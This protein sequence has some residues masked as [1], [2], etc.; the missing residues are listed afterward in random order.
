MARTNVELGQTHGAT[1]PHLRQTGLRCSAETATVGP[2]P[3]ETPDARV[4]RLRGLMQHRSEFLRA[5]VSDRQLGRRAAAGRLIRLPHGWYVEG[6]AWQALYAE[7]RH[8]LGVL[9][10]A[11]GQRGTTAGSGFLVFSYYSAAVLHRLPLYGFK[12]SRTHKTRALGAP[13]ARHSAFTV[14]H[15]ERLDPSSITDVAGVPCTDLARTAVDIAR[16]APPEMALACADAALLRLARL[17]G[18]PRDA[19]CADLRAAVLAGADALRF[20]QGISA[21]RHILSRADAR[22]ESPLE[23]IS[24]W[25]LERLGFEVDVQI[26]VAGPA[27]GC[28]WVDFELRGLDV[29]GEVDGAQKYRAD[30]EGSSQVAALHQ[31]EKRRADW[32]VGTTGKRLVRWGAADLASIERF[33]RRLEA[34]GLRI[35]RRQPW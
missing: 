5:H 25:Y 2:M 24:R 3:A 18:R 14:H 22:S 17:D 8:L 10:T 30:G 11:T 19:E 4:D 28:Y 27:G 29:L 12:A 20:S 31:R 26:P 23:S 16:I 9:A 21:A 34:F 33:A 7:D 15:Q 1:Y 13:R 6:A 32:I 35:P